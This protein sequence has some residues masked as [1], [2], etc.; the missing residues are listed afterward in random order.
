MLSSFSLHNFKGFPKNIRRKLLRDIISLILI[1]SSVL[2]AITLYHGAKIRH[3]ASATIIADTTTI[4]KKRFS[5]F[6]EPIETYLVMG[7]E[8]GKSGMLEEMS[9]QE[10][11]RM[12]I[13]MLTIS[14]NISA[15]MI[16]DSTGREFFL[17]RDEGKWL[18]R[19][20]TGDT[21]TRQASLQEWHDANHPLRS[22]TEIIDYDPRLRP[23]FTEIQVREK[24]MINWTDP[25][26]FFTEGRIGVTASIA[27]QHPAQETF[28][29]MAL[30]LLEDDLLAFLNSL[31]IGDHG[32]I[33]LIEEDGSIIAHNKNDRI[34]DQD[35]QAPVAR[36][37][38]I[39]NSGNR[40]KTSALEFSVFGRS[41]WAGF[42]PLNE[43]KEDAAWIM[44]IIPESEM[45]GDVRKSW[46]KIALIAVAILVLGF[47]LALR[48]VN[49]Y[50][51]QLRDLPQ[52]NISSSHGQKEIL[53]LIEAGE[54][55][56]LEF[57]S[58]MRMNLKTGKKGKEIEIAWL[59]TVAAFMNSDGGILL[60]GVEDN[61][62]IMGIERDGFENED[63]CRLYF[64]SLINHHIGPEFSRFVTL[65][66]F[67]LDEKMVL[68]I[69]CERVRKP[70]FLTVGK[71]EDFFVRSG[72]SSMKLSMSQMMQYL[73]E[74]P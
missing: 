74:R 70:V 61:G 17:K 15:I 23:W 52:Q 47:V 21:K 30:D 65:K 14:P 41:W 37:I 60:V 73:E 39:W 44:V 69:E 66:I 33:I 26:H 63:R 3:E 20:S 27:W 13:P 43:E 49:K 53:A 1:I 4:V 72:P 64:K 19:I 12:F 29:V 28:S 11:V 57:K 2:L 36:A 46:Q 56:T 22:W 55:A 51:Y 58:T 67:F 42:T 9:E 32:H 48:L 5:R 62:T 7:A 6:I 10:L 71:N 54:S 59:K 24:G 18:T 45:M 68:V 38:E 16:A 25:Y 50:S 34:E 40:Q 35:V 8:W 31:R